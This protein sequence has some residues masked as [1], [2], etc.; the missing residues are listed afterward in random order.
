MNCSDEKFILFETDILH[1]LIRAWTPLHACTNNPG[2]CAP[3]ALALLGAPRQVAQKMSYDVEESGTTYPKM[4][5][6]FESLV[7][8]SKFTARIINYEDIIPML[9]P[10]K[11]TLLYVYA[12]DG[13]TLPTH[14]T[15]LAKDHDGTIIIFDGQTNQYY[16]NDCA[17][18]YVNRY[19]HILVYGIKI[20]NKRSIRHEHSCSVRKN[21]SPEHKKQDTL[22]KT[23][24]KQTLKL[25]SRSK[26]SK[27]SSKSVSSRLNSLRNAFTKKISK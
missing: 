1:E 19:A 7:D 9:K 8:R 3:T 11:A 12:Y 20:K 23:P 2:N 5:H 24:Q 15:V 17:K 4:I 26:S 6:T 27:K 16:T 21:V 13:S 25:S 14:A 22:K 10:G 18:S